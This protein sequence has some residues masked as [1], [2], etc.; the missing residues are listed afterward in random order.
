MRS[1]FVHAASLDMSDGPSDADIAA[2]GAAITVE[3]CGHW[4]HSPPC[5]VAPHHTRAIRAD[6][7]VQIRTLFAVE[8]DDEPAVR[9]RID[10]ALRAGEL[11]RPDGVTRWTVRSSGRADVDDAEREHAGRLGREPA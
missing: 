4:E 9:Q 8:P 6:G 11:A 10:H 5:P 3:L 2:P 1:T 7:S